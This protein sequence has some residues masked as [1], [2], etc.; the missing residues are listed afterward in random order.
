MTGP[1][2]SWSTTFSRMI[3]CLPVTL[4]PLPQGS[5]VQPSLTQF[6]VG[7]ENHRQGHISYALCAWTTAPSSWEE[8]GS[9]GEGGYLQKF[10]DKGLIWPPQGVT[11]LSSTT[12]LTQHKRKQ[13]HKETR[14]SYLRSNLENWVHQ[15]EARL[16]LG[17]CWYQKQGGG[18]PVKSPALWEREVQT[19]CFGITLFL[20]AQYLDTESPLDEL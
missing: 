10:Q 3:I 17:K 8:P 5:G 1:S 18:F 14:K 2:W 16:G 19:L 15:S 13:R 4:I 11:P 9:D 7:V 20:Q 12:C 6:P